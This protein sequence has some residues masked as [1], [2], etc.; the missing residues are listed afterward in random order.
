MAKKAVSNP[1]EVTEEWLVVPL[2]SGAGRGSKPFIFESAR[3]IEVKYDSH[4]TVEPLEKALDD[5][6]GKATHARRFLCVPMGPGITVTIT[7]TVEITHEEY[8]GF[9]N[10]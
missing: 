10:L 3:V 7:P 9:R 1:D 4:L 5:V 6:F 8:S 2:K